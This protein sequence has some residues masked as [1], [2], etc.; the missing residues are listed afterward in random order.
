MSSN[1]SRNNGTIRVLTDFLVKNQSKLSL[2]NTNLVLRVVFIIAQN[3]SRST[4]CKNDT[5][6]FCKPMQIAACRFQRVTYLP[7]LKMHLLHCNLPAICLSI[8]RFFQL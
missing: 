4:F 7:R 3:G 2:R 1:F 5:D 6:L 8:H